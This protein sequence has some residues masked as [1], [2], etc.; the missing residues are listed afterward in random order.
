MDFF[1]FLTEISLQNV[2]PHNKDIYLKDLEVS[3]SKTTY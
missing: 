1:V 2:K 3:H